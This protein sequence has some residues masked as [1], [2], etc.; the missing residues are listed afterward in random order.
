MVS[1]VEH[2]RASYPDDNPKTVFGLKKPSM[3]S[4]PPT[5]LLH[6]MKA[7]ADGRAKYGL[8]NWREKTVSSTIYYDAAFRHMLAWYDGERL[9]D[10]SGVHHIGHAMACLA[11]I[12]DAEETG[13][14]NDDRPT[15]GVFADLV[16]EFT[17]KET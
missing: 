7:F 10:D 16:K 2:N 8:M 4:V 1:P 11:I 6:L 15:P 9:A 12:L 14:L 17:T 5:A 3:S 13:N